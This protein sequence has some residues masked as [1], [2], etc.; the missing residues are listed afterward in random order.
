MTYIASITIAIIYLITA[1]AF[2]IYGSL[3]T[4]SLL[5][6]R[7]ASSV[8][9]NSAER[10][11]PFSCCTLSLPCRIEL[12]SIGVSCCFI[13]ESIIWA[14]SVRYDNTTLTILFSLVDCLALCWVLFIFYAAIAKEGEKDKTEDGP[15]SR[16]DVGSSH[17]SSKTSK[18][19]R[20]LKHGESGESSIQLTSGSDLH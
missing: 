4:K 5:Q 20:R 2:V 6:V 10:S 16:S 7:S 14:I 1:I 15:R 19:V 3:L 9:Q 11:N 13:V 12:V 18:E 8:G 17:G